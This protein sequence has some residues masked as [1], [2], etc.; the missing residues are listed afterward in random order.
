MYVLWQVTVLPIPTLMM[1]QT[2]VLNFA[3]MEHIIIPT[4]VFIIALLI[5]LWMTLP[6]SV[7]NQWTVLQINMPTI[8]HAHV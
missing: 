7:L 1:I 3:P 8:K 2:H 6:R 4:F 5:G